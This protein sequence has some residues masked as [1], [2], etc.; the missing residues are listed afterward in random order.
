VRLLWHGAAPQLA[1]GYGLVAK[2][3][4]S[5]L[6]K[7]DVLSALGWMPI[8]MTGQAKW[9]W[10]GM[11]MYPVVDAPTMGEAVVGRWA[12]HFQ[13]DVVV[14]VTDHW[15]W[16]TDVWKQFTWVPIAFPDHIP[17]GEK[18]VSNLQMARKVV[19]PTEWGTDALRDAGVKQAEY[20]P[21]GVDISVFRPDGRDRAD[22]RMRMISSARQQGAPY[23]TE[24][25]FIF[26]MVA[27]NA[28]YPLRKCHDLVM[29]ATAQLLQRGHKD[30]LIYMH[31]MMDSGHNGPDLVRMLGAYARAYKDERVK[32]HVLFPPPEQLHLGGDEGGFSEERM[33]ALYNAM[34]CLLNPSQWEGFGLAPLEAQACGVPVIV[35][36]AGCQPEIGVAGWKVPVYRRFYANNTDTFIVEPDLN[37]LIHCMEAALRGAHHGEL[38]DKAIRHAQ[39][40]DWD[41]IVNDR[42]VPFLEGLRDGVS[43]AKKGLVAVGG[44]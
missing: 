30:F 25:C 20:I 36:D 12:K 19:V 22:Q 34:D 14:S 32:Y 29:D 31:S 10:E 43:A 35:T 2:H 6:R 24:D 28:T 37:G 17:M 42:W 15:V 9:K 23:L 33:A 38:K 41:D 11:P 3:I 21:L 27:R 8:G 39:R 40:Y 16:K 44:R 1:T 5:R 18:L 13:A 4:T 7:T 26:G